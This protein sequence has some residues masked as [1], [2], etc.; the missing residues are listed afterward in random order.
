MA[1]NVMNSPFVDPAIA[2][3]KGTNASIDLRDIRLALGGIEIYADVSFSVAPGEFLC[4]LG[5]SGCG[6]GRICSPLL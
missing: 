5:P 6:Q 1:M 2:T 3:R 4:I